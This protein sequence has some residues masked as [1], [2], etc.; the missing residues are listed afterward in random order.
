MPWENKLNL[1]SPECTKNNNKDRS[2]L[3]LPA[4]WADILESRSFSSLEILPKKQTDLNLLPKF[5]KSKFGLL[6][7]VLGEIQKKILEN[8]NCKILDLLPQG[9][10]YE[11]GNLR[12]SFQLQWNQVLGSITNLQL[13]SWDGTCSQIFPFFSS[14]QWHLR[15]EGFVLELILNADAKELLTGY[16]CAFSE[17]YRKRKSKLLFNSVLKN[18]LPLFLE[19]SIWLDLTGY[20]YLIYLCLKKHLQWNANIS[21]HN[22][23]VLDFKAL[24][25]QIEAVSGRRREFANYLRLL[26]RILKKLYEHGFLAPVDTKRFFAFQKIDKGDLQLIY[27]I[28]SHLNYE[29]EQDIYRSKVVKAILSDYLE[30]YE[31]FTSIFPMEGNL[32]EIK[33]ILEAI[34]CFDSPIKYQAFFIK[35]IFFVPY[36]LLLIEWFF[37]TRNS[38][39]IQESMQVLPLIQKLRSIDSVDEFC[40]RIEAL[41]SELFA[42]K[43]FYEHALNNICGISI[44][45]QAFLE[46]AHLQ[47][48]SSKQEPSDLSKTLKEVITIEES[49]NEKSKVSFRDEQWAISVIEDLQKKHHK[50][51]L[52]LKNDYLDSLKDQEKKLFIT[53]REKLS[54]E[55]FEKQLQPRLIRFL[56]ENES[57]NSIIDL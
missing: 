37:C 29:L 20:E 47:S 40:A 32:V 43:D 11:F 46:H 50:K 53:I 12:K 3:Y 8:K 27:Q 45:Q 24:L 44:C 48:N 34:N 33:K 14:S 10:L 9:W 42:A 6:V 55:A 7:C 18:R 52:Q 54:A 16:V 21:Q 4:W 56:I 2:L 17:S 51:F 13:L 23:F 41:L 57:Y 1:S 5:D 39:Q 31:F 19:Q 15:E 49:A 28:T 38:V 26:K 36:V 25:F 30:N 22:T 35:D